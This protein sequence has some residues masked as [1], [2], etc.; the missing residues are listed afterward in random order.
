MEQPS[1]QTLHHRQFSLLEK[2]PSRQAIDDYKI[3]LQQQGSSKNLL[4]KFT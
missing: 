2:D 3:K 4:D 1:H